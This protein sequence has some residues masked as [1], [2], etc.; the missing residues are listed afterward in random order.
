MYSTAVVL[1]LKSYGVNEIPGPWKASH[2]DGER[3]QSHAMI[4]AMNPRGDVVAE[5]CVGKERCGCGA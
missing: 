1:R 4:V 3:P 5:S 2:I